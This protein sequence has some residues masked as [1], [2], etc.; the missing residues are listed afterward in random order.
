MDVGLKIIAVQNRMG[1]SIRLK[2][3]AACIFTNPNHVRKDKDGLYAMVSYI[4]I[5]QNKTVLQG[6]L[7]AM[8]PSKSLVTEGL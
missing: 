7:M 3:P 1:K 8:Q 5:Q 4:L 6:C 2:M